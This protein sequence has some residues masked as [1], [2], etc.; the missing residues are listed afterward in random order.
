MIIKK[1]ITIFVLII[2]AILFF[3]LGS[4]IQKEG[5]PITDFCTEHYNNKTFLETTT[6]FTQDE[7]SEP[8]QCQTDTWRT[9]KWFRYCNSTCFENFNKCLE[10]N[11][12][13]EQIYFMN[14]CHWMGPDYIIL[15]GTVIF[16]FAFPLMFIVIGILLFSLKK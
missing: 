16:K 9:G 13:D 4:Y 14:K 8:L 7:P 11:A 2:I 1:I 6:Y 5:K 12:T 15:V 3:S 10:E